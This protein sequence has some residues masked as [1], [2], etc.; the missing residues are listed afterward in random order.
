MNKLIMMVGLPA[1]GK[2]TIA[3]KIAIKENAIIHASDELRKELFDDENV[4]DKNNE[5]F[6]E[7]HKRIKKDLYEGKNVVY[8]ATN[9]HYKRRKSFLD[10]LNKLNIYK[11]CVVIA[12]P[13]EECLKQNKLRERQVP[14]YVIKKMYLNFYVP[15]YYEGWNEIRFVYNKHTTRTYIITELLYRLKEIDQDNPY[16]TLTIGNHCRKCTEIVEQKANDINLSYAA[17]LHDIGKE[18]TKGFKNSKGEDTDIAHYYQ[19]HLVSAYDSL[20]YLDSIQNASFNL[21]K[22]VGL[23]TWHMQPFFIESEKAKNKFINL[24]GQEFYDKLMI[25]HEADKMAK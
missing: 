4:N 22:T 16:H 17:L 2:S 23:I 5:L 8:D 18:F 25:L 24:V 9:I 19:H 3:K 15:Q 14:D 11:E 1:S 10:E 20:F 12:T 13:Y 6:V 21:L 7:L